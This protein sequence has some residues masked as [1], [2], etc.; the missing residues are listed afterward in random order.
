MTDECVRASRAFVKENVV[1]LVGIDLPADYVRAGAVEDDVTGVGVYD[2]IKRRAIRR[3]RRRAGAVADQNALV[4]VSI[5]EKN[6]EPPRVLGLSGNH[7]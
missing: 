2:R 1:I 4:C 7:I 6:L 3:G 5:P